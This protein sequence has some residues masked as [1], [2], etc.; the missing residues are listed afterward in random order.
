MHRV[1]GDFAATI[2]LVTWIEGVALGAYLDRAPGWLIVGAFFGTL[3]FVGL[4]FQKRRN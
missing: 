1:D 2:A 4:V 3:L